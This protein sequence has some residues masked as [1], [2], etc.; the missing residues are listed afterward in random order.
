MPAPRGR[1][2]STLVVARCFAYLLMK[3]SV[4]F[5]RTL[6]DSPWLLPA[7]VVLALSAGWLAGQLGTMV[8]GLL[9]VG[10]ILFFLTILIFR[11][12]RVGILTY[13][14]YCFLMGIIGRNIETGVQ[15]GLG[16]DAILALTWI[17]VVFQQQGRLDWSRTNNDV[18]WLVLG[19][20]VLTVLEIANPA[21]A[22]I[23]GWLYEMRSTA[24]YMVMAIPLGCLLLYRVRDLRLFLKIII[25]F[26]VFG[27]IYGVKQKVIG[28]NDMEQEW[29]DTGGAVTHLIFGKLR[30][31]SYY[32]EA[33]QFGASQAHVA[34]ICLILALGPFVLWKRVAFG[35]SA[36]ACFYGMLISGTRGALFVLVGGMFLYLVLSKK[37]RPLMV[38]IVLA[39]GAII[40]LKY[41]TIGS[42]NADVVRF[43]TALDPNDPSLQLRLMNQAKLS[44]YLADYPLGGGVGV[45]GIWGQKFNQDKYLSTVAPDSYFVKIWAEYGIVG[46]ILW[47]GMMLYILGK[48]CAIVWKLRNPQ[49]RQMLLALT[50]G[51]GGI[52]LSSYGNE[53]INQIPSSMIIYLSLA[54]IIQG[55]AFDD[56]LDPQPEIRIV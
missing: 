35:I 15:L 28:L 40:F 46:F 9:L 36:A 1:P 6:L 19:W 10:P 8:P 39:L 21:G 52:L 20:F 16:M 54:F 51:Y 49:L 12:P 23:M 17:A 26:S 14:V 2:P 32:S 4:P 27:A 50:A 29:L 42:G 25:G 24:L 45:I 18:C 37:I 43:R 3:P 41:T 30:I 56:A 38:G 5:S 11:S 34:L 22:S 44:R 13:V 55:P 31:F 48:C 7:S 47:F 53:V 33:A